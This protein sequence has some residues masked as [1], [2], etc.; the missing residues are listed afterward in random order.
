[1]LKIALGVTDPIKAEVA[2]AQTVE[3]LGGVDVLVAAAGTAVLG[4]GSQ[5][6]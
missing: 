6:C 1:M 3:E 5:L 2:V 4:A